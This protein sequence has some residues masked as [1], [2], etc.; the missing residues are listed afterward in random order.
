MGIWSYE[1]PEDNPCF[2]LFNFFIFSL[3]SRL[4]VRTISCY[5]A[6]LEIRD[7]PQELSHKKLSHEMF[8]PQETK[9]DLP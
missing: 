1:I 2:A 6:V 8:V 7:C 9:L 5:S 4:C 3:K